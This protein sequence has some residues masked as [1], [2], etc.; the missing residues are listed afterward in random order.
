MASICPIRWIEISMF[1]KK[2]YFVF[3]PNSDVAVVHSS[4]GLFFLLFTSH[5]QKWSYLVNKSDFW[6]IFFEKWRYLVRFLSNWIY[7]DLI[8]SHD[9]SKHLVQKSLLFTKYDIFWEYDVKKQQ[10]MSLRGMVDNGP[11]I[12]GKVKIWLF[13]KSRDFDLTYGANWS[14][15]QLDIHLTIPFN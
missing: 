10:K 13:R 8:K 12:L 7:L 9:F 11:Q 2:P 5:S 1:L 14:H 4:L 3:F 6:T 15:I